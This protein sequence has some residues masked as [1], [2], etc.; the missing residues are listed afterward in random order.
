MASVSLKLIL[1]LFLKIFIYCFILNILKYI[2]NFIC[3]IYLID[4]FKH[5]QLYGDTSVLIAFYIANGKM[6]YIELIKFTFPS[7]YNVNFAIPSLYHM[8]KVWLWTR[9]S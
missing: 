8:V 9:Q 4:F 5:H 2:L 7:L 1:L 3:K 6:N